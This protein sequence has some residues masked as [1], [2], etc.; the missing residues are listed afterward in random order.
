LS[1]S[2]H[3][4]P[5]AMPD[6][7]VAISEIGAAY[8]VLNTVTRVEPSSPAAQA[9]LQVGDRI[10]KVRFLPP[11]KEQLAALQAKYHDESIGQNEVTHSFA[12]KE[13]NWP[14]FMLDLQGGLPGTTVEFTW[15][16]GEEEK[17]AK[18]APV[19][20]TDWFNPQPG[21]S[22]EAQ[23][24]VQ[25]ADTF[26]E[27]VRLGGRETVDA[28]FAVYR[29]L[30]SVVGTQQISA[31]NFSGPWGIVMVA[32]MAARQ[33]LGTFLIFLTLLSANLAVINFLP[34]PVLDGGH[35]VLLLYEGIRGKPADERVQE[36]LT[37]IGL[38]LILSLMIFVF[39]L[40]FG[41]ISRPGA[42]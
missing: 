1:S 7:P 24:F 40:D 27:A 9:G 30:H 16:H 18:L 3:Y 34:I 36:I 5:S 32:L 15:K 38:I 39:G 35:I 6:S 11:S 22:L 14:F 26:S 37:W 33:G 21:W 4:A 19:E 23:N 20:A 17:T 8:Y 29:T 31:R 12:E 42:H 2:P 41:L 28:A 13:R 10:T 25:K